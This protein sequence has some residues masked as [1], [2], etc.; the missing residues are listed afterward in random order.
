MRHWLTQTALL[1]GIVLFLAKLLALPSA[2]AMLLAAC[3]ALATV[4]VGCAGLTCLRQQ[5]GRSPQPAAPPSHLRVARR[6]LP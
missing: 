6:L 2:G 1:G 5:R 3:L 4:H